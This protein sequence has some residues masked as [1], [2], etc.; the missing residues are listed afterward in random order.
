ME[1]YKSMS[2]IF[3]NFEDPD[4]VF[5][6]DEGHVEGDHAMEGN[7]EQ[8]EQDEDR[9]INQKLK[10]IHRNLGHPNKETM[11]RMLR[12][13][14]ADERTLRVAQNFECATCLQRG[15]RAPARPAAVMKK[16]N[17][18]ECV[19]MDTFW[20]HTPKEALN[21]G[22]KPVYTIGLSLMDEATDYHVAVIIK[23]SKDGPLRNISADDFRRAFSTG[24]LRNFPAPSLLRYDEE[25]FMRSLDIA[26]WLEV[27]GM[28]LE[29][30]AGEGAWQMGKHSKHLQT[31]KEQMNLLS[32]ELEDKFSPDEL[33]GLAL[34]AK[35]GMHQIRGY[36]PNQWALGQ[37]HSRISSFL[38][39]SANLPWDSAREDISFEAQLQAEAKARQHFLQIDAKRR[40]ARS[41]H[42]RCRTLREFVVG[43]LVY[44]FRKGTRQGLRYGGTWHGPARV[45]AQEK[46]SPLQDEAAAGSIVWVS[47]AG[48][49]IRCCPEQ[50]RHVTQDLRHV[51]R[52]ING[53][54]NYF[55][56]LK[57]VAN[58]Q[59]Y[60]DLSHHDYSCLDDDAVPDEQM[61]HFRARGKQSVPDLHYGPR[62]EPPADPL[63]NV[64]QPLQSHE[65]QDEEGERDLPGRSRTPTSGRVRSNG[66]EGREASGRNIPRDL[67]RQRI[68]EVGGCTHSKQSQVRSR[69]E[70]VRRLHET[71]TGRRDSRGR[72]SELGRSQEEDERDR[73]DQ[74]GRKRP[75][76]LDPSQLFDR[77]RHQDDREEE[78]PAGGA[79]SSS[80]RPGVGIQLE[81]GGRCGERDGSDEGPPPSDGILVGPDSDIGAETGTV[82]V[83]S[84]SPHSAYEPAKTG[85][86]RRQRS[87]LP[88][89]D[90]NLHCRLKVGRG[91]FFENQVCFAESVGDLDVCEFE[92]VL[93]PRDVHMKG[94]GIWMVNSKARKSAEVNI[95]K[96]NEEDRA[97]FE[98]AM[99]KELD[100]FLSSE[101]IQIC[102]SAGIPPERIMKM[103]WIHS[104]KAVHDE[105]GKETGKKAKSRLII[106]GFEDPRLTTLPREAPTLSCLGRNL[107]LA[108]TARRR[109]VL[110][111]GDIRTAFLQ[112]NKSELKEE[113]Y[114]L[115]PEDVRLSLGMTPEQILRIAKAIYGLLN[116]PKK[117]YEALSEFLINDGWLI[118]SLDKCLFKRLDENGFVC[119][120]LGIH[121][122][123]VLT[124]GSGDIYERSIERLR[125][126]FTFGSWESAW[127]HTVQYCGCEIK[128]HNDGSI[129]VNQQKFALSVDEISISHERKM[130]PTALLTESEKSQMR[131]RLGALNWRATQTAPWLLSTVS[132]LQGCVEGGTIQDLLSTNKLIRLQIKRYD[133]GLCFPVLK[134]ECTLCTF[135]DASWATRRDGS[136]Q[137][138]Q[139]TLLMQK[140]ILTGQVSPFSVLS[141]SSRRL[142]R[143]ARSSTSA[144]AQ[145][146][147]NALDLHEFA[148]LGYYDLLHGK[149]L[150]L[151]RT[152]EYLREIESCMICDARN[153][154]DGI[155][156]V[157]TSG[158]HM[159]E[160]RTAIELLAIKERL[161]QANVCLRWVDGEQELADGL[162]KPWKHEP[163]IRALREHAWKIVYDPKFQS[164]RKK[165]IL[166]QNLYVDEIWLTTVL[167]LGGEQIEFWTGEKSVHCS[168]H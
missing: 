77:D 64:E 130:E 100:S 46:T 110:K 163:L 140:D 50:L 124:S 24:W 14:G 166:Q 78:D 82:D 9:E 111:T 61:P 117:W 142:K 36:S 118:H 72:S 5:V 132:H 131:Q 70:D 67:Q 160:K 86:D 83:R 101:A 74:S 154:Y 17:K 105:S 12:D 120:Y 79:S 11:I 136:S 123:D 92:L 34:S 68:S 158:L 152:D 134:G 102:S 7:E 48:R 47:H 63:P 1:D 109:F 25:G 33:L 156:K 37:D 13:A 87:G 66:H 49:I 55:D 6:E 97:Q 129:T 21:A 89:R 95:R 45:L 106:R 58:Q 31:L 44:Y 145:M 80:R 19:S 57:D 164:A 40:I 119:G 165:R 16:Y 153:I 71:P 141:W 88:S 149:R 167:S 90:E 128:Q 127:E 161:N 168:P 144:E 39:Q 30:I 56:L 103:K 162:T 137:G 23:T 15:R 53:P 28:R 65:D 121:V 32:L 10:V 84:R 159:E 114:G 139:I 26:Q 138:G 98:A 108:E 52:Q 91:A 27:F 148:K 35:N 133:E 99:R 22:C 96:L 81:P 115:P 135:T 94:R 60:L 146:S 125:N 8:H 73:K 122:D 69:H 54:Q 116:A 75:A 150:D 112:G 59:K 2:S 107:L 157:E 41:L 155:C 51:D 104:W 42:A 143:V 62:R 126:K 29:P 20:W 151:R 18:W 38:Q 85:E 43:D 147:G 113:V 3:A 93:A 76:S 4:D